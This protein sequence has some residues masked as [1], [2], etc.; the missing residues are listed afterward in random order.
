VVKV[1][2]FPAFNAL[3]MLVALEVGVKPLGVAAALD[4]KSCA[5][6]T[7]CQ[8]GPVDGVQRYV[9]Q[10]LAD[11]AEDHFRRRVL[12]GLNKGFIDLHPLGRNL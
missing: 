1:K 7:Q 6:F 3:E 5:N 10:H 2:N 12:S 9:R 11:F 4:D 8:Q